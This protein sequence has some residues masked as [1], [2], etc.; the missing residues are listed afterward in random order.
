M[1][2]DIQKVLD[3]LYNIDNNLRQHEEKLINIINELFL[4]RP[5]TKF[6]ENFSKKLRKEV[7]LRARELKETNRA[8]SSLNFMLLNKFGYALAGV[9]LTLL[10]IIPILNLKTDTSSLKSRLSEADNSFKIAKL[11]KGAF[12]SLGSDQVLPEM[13]RVEK[14]ASSISNDES[15]AEESIQT[16]AKKEAGIGAGGGGGLATTDSRIG[17]APNII[18][19][20]YE[21]IG[22]E[23]G[24]LKEKMAVYNPSN[25]RLINN[26]SRLLKNFSLDLIDLGK[27][28]S[29]K[30]QNISLTEDREYGYMVYL[31]MDQG[32]ASI[33]K[34]WKNWPDPFKDCRDE[35]CY[36]KGRLT[37]DNVPGDEEIVKIADKFLRDY[38]I[39]LKSYGAGQVR[40]TW[41]IDYERTGEDYMIP[42]SMQV[43][44]PLIIDGK[45]VYDGSGY[46]TGIMV[47][48]SL[49][50]MKAAGAHR[51]ISLNFESS[52]Y[53]TETDTEKLIMV[54]ENGGLR[55]R[56]SHPEPTETVNVKLNTPKVGLISHWHYDQEKREGKEIFIPALIF[57]ISNK[58][59]AKNMYQDSI[60]VPLVKEILDERMDDI[61][62]L[63]EP[64]P[65]PMPLLRMDVG[66][67]MQ[68]EE[69]DVGINSSDINS[70][71]II[72]YSDE[73]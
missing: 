25:K 52:E 28:G 22:E 54:A 39:D 61:I 64:M 35:E 26:F 16:F 23:I 67:D 21:Y 53:E 5:D 32:Q 63:P 1:N 41:R 51:I 65:I 24:E 2:K 38:N 14:S 72:E 55:G 4:S 11:S 12:G 68:V 46:V 49:R 57:P 69:D 71:E 42:E 60:A 33:N 6:D 62:G 37:I 50:D 40:D 47:D 30:A 27:F 31:N 8:S 44:Y 56:Y 29:L 20:E 73:E 34:D 15:L 17:F 10:L 18:N 43:V 66:E 36:K 13:D 45:T 3:D 58:D 9:A 48:V 59:E 19:Y 7:L 70:E